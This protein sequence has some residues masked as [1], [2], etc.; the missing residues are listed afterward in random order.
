MADTQKLHLRLEPVSG[1][2]LADLIQELGKTPK[3]IRE[4]IGKLVN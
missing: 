1:A 3:D 2:K 4:Q